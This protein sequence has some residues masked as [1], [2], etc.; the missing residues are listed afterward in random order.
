MG[1][2]GKVSVCVVVVSLRDGVW[3][4]CV[5]VYLQAGALSAQAELFYGLYLLKRGESFASFI[6]ALTP[7]C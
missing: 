5:C 6:N 3:R 4:V 7:Q 2:D 1:A